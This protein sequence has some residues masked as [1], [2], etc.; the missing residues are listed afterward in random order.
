MSLSASQAAD[1]LC[2]N[3]VD[4]I[5]REDLLSRLKEFEKDKKPLRIKAGFDPS[6][7][8]IHL[9]HTVLLRKLRQFQDLGHKVIFIIGDY[10]AMI[11]DPTG[12]T[13]TRPALSRDEVQNNAKTYQAQAFKILD[14]D[15]SKIE[16]VNNSAWFDKPE[17]FRVLLETIGTNYTVARLLERD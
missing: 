8:D 1:L 16:I 10:T 5:D 6:A 17:M 15:P 11:G 3:T 13:T 2:R 14:P 9:G 12:K 4:V 7:P